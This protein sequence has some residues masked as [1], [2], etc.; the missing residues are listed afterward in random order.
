M[1]YKLTINYTNKHAAIVN[2]V[3]GMYFEAANGNSIFLPAAA[4][5]WW[6]SSENEWGINN[7]GTGAYWTS[8]KSHYDNYFYF[9]EFDDGH[10]YFSDRH[11]D[12]NKLTIRAVYNEAD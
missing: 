5:L 10:A 8:T 11:K 12:R 4:H 1:S 9:L 7:A 3:N 2:G 6:D